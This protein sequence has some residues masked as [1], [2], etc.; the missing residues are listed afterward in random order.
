M[1]KRE[2]KFSDIVKQYGEPLLQFRPEGDF[3]EYD[4]FQRDD[5]PF[6]VAVFSLK[7][8]HPSEVMVW[9][10]Y[11]GEQWYPNSAERYV[12]RHLLQIINDLSY[13][14]SCDGCSLLGYDQ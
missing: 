4:E 7:G 13:E 3:S 11:G 14:K 1:I 10:N 6:E 5:V 8:K 2:K 9:H 12:I